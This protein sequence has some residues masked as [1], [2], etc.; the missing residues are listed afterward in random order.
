MG[1]LVTDLLQAR[2]GAERVAAVKALAKKRGMTMQSLVSKLIDE[3]TGVVSSHTD[4]IRPVDGSER[5]VELAERQV[6]LLEQLVA[7][8]RPGQQLTEN[9]VNSLMS[10]ALVEEI[11]ED[12]VNSV[13]SPASSAAVPAV[14]ADGQQ[15]VAGVRAK[16]KAELDSWLNLPGPEVKESVS[17]T[18]QAVVITPSPAPTEEAVKRKKSNPAFAAALRS[19]A[20]AVVGE[21]GDQ[22]PGE[23]GSHPPGEADQAPV[24]VPVHLPEQL[25]GGA[26]D[27]EV[28]AE[29]QGERV[30][31]GIDVTPA[32]AQIRV[33]RQEQVGLEAPGAPPADSAA[34]WVW[35]ARDVLKDLGMAGDLGEVTALLQLWQ[36]PHD[37]LAG[38]VSELLEGLPNYERLY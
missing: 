24:H 19:A 12:S 5:L 25:S 26:V 30:Q 20:A 38:E 32:A 17:S 2:V 27:V 31:A 37:L 23:S 10:P 9:P 15:L 8:C 11:T 13:V 29:R 4:A 21:Q 34:E 14:E 33:W 28:S 6:E 18:S 1:E 35:A 16:S 22:A 36:C 3:A 7:G